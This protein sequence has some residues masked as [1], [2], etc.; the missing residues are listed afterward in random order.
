MHDCVE[1][2]GGGK[3]VK[4]RHLVDIRRN[5]GERRNVAGMNL[6]DLFVPL[7]IDEKTK[8]RDISEDGR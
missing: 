7:K 2:C 3:A 8:K 4:H 5:A 6:A 1:G